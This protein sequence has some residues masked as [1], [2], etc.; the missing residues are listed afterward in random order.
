M[1]GKG[2][3]AKLREVFMAKAL[4]VAPPNVGARTT[5][6][7]NGPDG[8][9]V[10]GAVDFAGLDSLTKQAISPVDSGIVAW[11]GPREDGF[12][13]DTPGI[14]DFLDPRIVNNDGDGNDGLGQDDGGVDGFKGFNVLTFA[15]QN[16]LTE[17]EPVA[18]QAPLLG[19]RT[20]VGVY[21]S[22]SRRA[23]TTRRTGAAPNS[24]GSWV[25]VNRLGNPLF[26][27]VLVAL[28]D[29]DRYNWTSPE[30]DEDYRKYAENP[31]VAF[32]IN[33][34]LFA[35]PEGDGPLATTGR[36]DLAAI[37]LPDVIRVDTTT[38][39]VKLPGQAGFNRLSLIGGDTAGW[40]HGYRRPAMLPPECRRSFLPTRH[41]HEP[42]LSL[43]PSRSNIRRSARAPRSRNP[44]SGEEGIRR[45]GT[46][47]PEAA[48]ESQGRRCQHLGAAR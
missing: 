6:A 23:T 29:K 40:P 4:P 13:A 2:R 42:S 36:T 3:N 19:A 12:Y 14:F 8:K 48:R 22:V 31:E 17:L 16:P 44:G 24:R 26:N 7:Y 39:P 34:V 32:L 25:Q 28:R 45:P 18:Y 33:A 11:A 9:A 38:G 47:S 15:V 5:P 27:E 35:D 21:A 46:G 43:S 41:H 37:F 30:N 10:S 20:G 1:S